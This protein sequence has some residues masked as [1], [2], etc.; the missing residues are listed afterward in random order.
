MELQCLHSSSAESEN[1]LYAVQWFHRMNVIHYWRFYSIEKG[2][3]PDVTT[4]EWDCLSGWDSIV[5]AFMHKG[6][7]ER[8]VYSMNG[9]QC[10]CHRKPGGWRKEP[11][12]SDPRSTVPWQSNLHLCGVTIGLIEGT[13]HISLR[14]KLD[15]TTVVGLCWDCNVSTVMYATSWR[16]RTMSGSQQ[17]HVSLKEKCNIKLERE[18]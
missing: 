18:V 15:P 6:K 5:N 11:H 12:Q 1:G 7:A 16:G 8:E 2:K 9:I 17:W 14:N 4:S 3:S 13:K 10:H